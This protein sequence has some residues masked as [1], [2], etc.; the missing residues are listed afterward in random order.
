M[1]AEEQKGDGQAA[2]PME[3]EDISIKKDGGVLKVVFLCK[4]VFAKRFLFA[5]CPS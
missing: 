5:P 3:G 2:V 4:R 1:T